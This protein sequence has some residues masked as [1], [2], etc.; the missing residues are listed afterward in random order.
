ML[1][2]GRPRFLWS[3]FIELRI[4]WKEKIKDGNKKRKY[5]VLGEG[6]SGLGHI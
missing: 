6:D 2:G 3:Q 4:S 1:K 5:E